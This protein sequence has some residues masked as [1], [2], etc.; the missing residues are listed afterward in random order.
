MAQWVNAPQRGTKRGNDMSLNR[1]GNPRAVPPIA[2]S[3][4]G[5]RPPRKDSNEM[6]ISIESTRSTMAQQHG[7][8]AGHHQGSLSSLPEDQLSIS[9]ELSRGLSNNPFTSSGSFNFNNSASFSGTNSL[10]STSGG[11]ASFGPHGSGVGGASALHNAATAAAASRY[12]LSVERGMVP[13]G[14]EYEHEVFE[15]DDEEDVHHYHYDDDSRGGRGGGSG[16][17]DY[18]QQEEKKSDDRYFMNRGHK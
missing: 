3:A 13:E 5:G 16:G 10:T 4:A 12:R 2:A 11:V 9:R 7:G 6:S 1:S 8:F 18:K 15:D 17:Y 14:D